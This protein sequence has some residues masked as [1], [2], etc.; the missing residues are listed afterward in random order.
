M[1]ER[2]NYEPTLQVINVSKCFFPEISVIMFCSLYYPFKQVHV[3][4]FFNPIWVTLAI[5]SRRGKYRNQGNRRIVNL[6]G[7]YRLFGL[8]IKN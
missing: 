8:E 1:H 3:K 4:E 2:T 6:S 5:S 7:P